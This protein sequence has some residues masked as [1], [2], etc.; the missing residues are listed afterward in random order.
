MPVMLLCRLLLCVATHTADILTSSCILSL[1][2]TSSWSWEANE[3][4][5]IRQRF[6][7]CCAVQVRNMSG[8]IF[9][10][11]LMRRAFELAFAC[12]YTFAGWRPQ[13]VRC[14]EVSQ[15]SITMASF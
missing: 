8:R 10:G 15:L 1:V 6:T 5:L 2:K 9:G 3:V 13:F 7:I 14:E 4:F 11:F 12:S